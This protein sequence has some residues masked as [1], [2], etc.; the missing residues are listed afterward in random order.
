[1]KSS[2]ISRLVLGYGIIILIVVLMVFTFAMYITIH[3]VGRSERVFLDDLVQKAQNLS[4]KTTL[5]IS[6]PTQ[7]NFISHTA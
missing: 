5:Q 6:E 3:K 7:D 1:M 2:I 4:L